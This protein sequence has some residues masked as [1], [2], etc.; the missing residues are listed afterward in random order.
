[1]SS[2][3]RLPKVATVRAESANVRA[4]GVKLVCAPLRANARSGGVSDV[5]DRS[6]HWLGAAGINH[7]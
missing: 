1:M 4:V 3:L 7:F 6:R 2:G 5:T